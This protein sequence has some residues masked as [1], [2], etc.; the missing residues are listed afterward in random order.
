MAFLEFSDRR[1][2]GLEEYGFMD[3]LVDGLATICGVK[4]QPA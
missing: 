1:G 2:G 3:S 4:G